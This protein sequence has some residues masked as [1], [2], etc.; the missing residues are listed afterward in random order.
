MED[1][2]YILKQLESPKSGLYVETE[3]YFLDFHI[4][5]EKSLCVEID[6][7]NN[8]FWAYSDIDLTKAEFILTIV[9]KEE[10]I[11]TTDRIWDAYSDFD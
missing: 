10:F 2:L 5:E 6:G 4:D 8:N 1:A 7:I 3:K 9:S 11:P